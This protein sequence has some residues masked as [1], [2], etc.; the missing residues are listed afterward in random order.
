VGCFL[1][2]QLP[3]TPAHAAACQIRKAA[4][5][6]AEMAFARHD[7]KRSAELAAAAFKSDPADRHSRELE[8][9]SL[10]AEEKLEEASKKADA[11]TAAEPGDAY[12][13]TAAS[14][15]RQAQG[16]WLQAYVL[17]LKAL[18]IDPCI[19][20]AYEDLAEYES[21]AGYHAASRKHLDLARQLAPNDDGIRVAWID[22]LDPEHSIA[23]FKKYLDETKAIDQ[24]RRASLQHSLDVAEA[25]LKDACELAS[26]SGPPRIPMV[27][28]YGKGMGVA[29][30]GLEVAFNGH[31]RILQIDTG[32]SGFLL[33]R[34]V[35][36]GMKLV[37]ENTNRIGGFGDQGST[38]AELYHADTVRLGGVEFRN[39][40]V[41]ALSNSGVLGGGTGL[42]ERLD[43]GDGL[44]G[45]DIFSRYLVTVDYQRLEIRLEPLPQPPTAPKEELDEL[46]GSVKND[47]SNFDRYQAPSMKGWTN[48]YRRGHMLIVPAAVNEK[49]P[50]LF[51]V[52]TGSFANL[53][54]AGAA[55]EITT[56]KESMSGIR[57]LSGTSRLF[58]AGKFTLD[59]AGMRLPVKSMDS[60][61]LSTFGGVKGFLGYPTLTQL[62]MHIDYRDN[63]VHF[64]VAG[65]RR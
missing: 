1:A 40:P 37:K 33:T 6:E 64:E 62:I 34:S 35:A 58:E 31:K 14:E 8:I 27:P 56:S 13:I 18:K 48:I 10:L 28:V 47:L 61:N 41:E 57:G 42:G 30:Y 15:V 44:V 9:D 43:E 54:D 7:F 49:Q 38:A 21:V 45:T 19:P 20:D 53:I 65:A 32:A 39:C 52:D 17:A 60:V 50:M 3:A 23:E 25:R 24:K 59:F 26:L 63:L 55:K 16:E 29:Y 46:G 22:S 12:A 2:A 4:P 5:T 36:S 51:V 11:W